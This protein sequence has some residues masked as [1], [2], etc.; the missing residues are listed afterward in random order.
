MRCYWE[1]KNDA[2]W[3]KGTKGLTK[4]NAGSFIK[5][6]I[7][8]KGTLA[9]YKAL[10]WRIGRMLGKPRVCDNC[11]KLIVTP[12][13][14]DWANISGE[15]KEVKED[16]I[17]LCRKCHYEFDKQEFRRKKYESNIL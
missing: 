17:R 14:I 4:V 2:P 6:K 3:N 8:F 11:K 12:K 15:Y 1:R 5:V 9:Q 10:H 7:K 13:G 16:W